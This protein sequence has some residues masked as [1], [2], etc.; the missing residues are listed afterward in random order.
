MIESAFPIIEVADMEVALAFYRDGL[1]GEVRYRFPPEGEPVYVSLAAG[2]S[3]I[4]L[5]VAEAPL[6]PGNVVLWF[7]VDDVDRVTAAL[8]ERG[9][10]VIEAP[11]DQPWG[12][13][14]ALVEDPFGTRVRL[15]APLGDAGGEH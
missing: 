10:P 13:R 6:P 5:G 7:Y 12:E 2:S 4:G 14:I 15:G 9:A 8:A 3:T 1:G 11:A